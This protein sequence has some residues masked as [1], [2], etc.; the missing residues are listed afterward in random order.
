[1][2]AKIKERLGIGGFS[3]KE[4][5]AMIMKAVHEERGFHEAGKK[6]AGTFTPS[7]M[8]DTTFQSENVHFT[9]AAPSLHAVEEGKQSRVV[10]ALGRI[11]ESMTGGWVSVG[12]RGVV[13]DRDIIQEHLFLAQDAIVL[14]VKT[15]PHMS[16]IV[17]NMV[18]YS[19]GSGVKFDCP[20][21]EIKK[22]LS[23][24]R[25]ENMMDRRERK[26]MREIY[27]EGEYFWSYS[28][29]ETTGKVRA[30]KIRPK[31]ILHI[32]TDPED[33]ETRRSY[34]R[35]TGEFN[36][37]GYWIN[38]I[39]MLLNEE[40]VS[41]IAATNDIA[42]S[43]D[44]KHPNL[45][46]QFSRY[47]NSDEL[48]GWPP[49]YCI[50]KP[51]KFM[52]QFIVDRARLH[53]ERSKVVWFMQRKGKA[54]NRGNANPALAPEGGTMWIEDD[55]VTYRAHSLDLSSADAAQDA[56][57]IL[58]AM[59][60]G[61]K[62][63][64]HVWNQRTDQAV[65][66]SINKAETP[67]SQ[68]INY[69]Q[70]FADEE[71]EIRDHFVIEAAKRYGGLKPTVQIPKYDDEITIKALSRINDMV[72]EGYS[73]EAI[74]KEAKDILAPGFKMATME[75]HEVPITRTFPKVV[76]EAPLDMAK[77]LLIHQKLGIASDATIAAKAGYNWQDE[78]IRRMLEVKAT[79]SLDAL[80]QKAFVAA[81]G[82]LPGN[83][84][85]G[86]DPANPGG[87]KPPQKQNGGRQPGDGAG[88]IKT[89]K[90]KA[91]GGDIE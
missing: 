72:A 5:E 62:S 11:L 7:G 14:R 39:S 26:F 44:F 42:S 12:G 19:I 10:S 88:G 90:D 76:Q 6:N 36:N 35:R 47:G 48:R 71:F 89:K 24:F 66:A 4:V 60:S 40:Y 81:G 63:P 33:M 52:D 23:V 2:L 17:D 46:L 55:T 20:S 65:Y 49:L 64:I 32:N 45:Y 91:D 31:E 67:F 54:D 87:P 57:L 13:M 84:G 43:K 25:R 74:E 16:G 79:A 21:P 68:S 34:F 75:V 50:L 70:N 15:D 38:D 83:G 53:H 80:K 82:V 59:S 22:A 8:Y 51:A 61:A 28:V 77:V 56:L 18:Y 73:T 78:F 41:G 58:Y 27:Q 86:N 29:D 1:M 30:R 37:E 3:K 9:L 85:D 69:Q